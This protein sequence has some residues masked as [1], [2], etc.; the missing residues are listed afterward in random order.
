MGLNAAA[1]WD[2]AMVSLDCSEEGEG[3]R[4]RRDFD[5]IQG[6]CEIELNLEVTKCGI[7][8]DKGGMIFFFT[9]FPLEAR[10]DM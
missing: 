6:F 5:I 10:G 4:V 8:F 2:S 9:G 1:K 3:E 7:G